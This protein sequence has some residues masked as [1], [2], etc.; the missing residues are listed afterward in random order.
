LSN[1][2]ETEQGLFTEHNLETKNGEDEEPQM[3]NNEEK[4]YILAPFNSIKSMFIDT[5]S[6]SSRA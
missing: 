3:A 1:A 4:S 6:Q 5:P 2:L